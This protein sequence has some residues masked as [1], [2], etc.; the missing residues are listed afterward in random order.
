M[1]PHTA[2]APVCEMD[3]IKSRIY[4]FRRG[5]VIVQPLGGS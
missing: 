4:L 1:R 3:A 2:E 5:Q